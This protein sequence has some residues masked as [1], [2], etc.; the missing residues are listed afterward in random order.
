MTT[1]ITTGLFLQ[2]AYQTLFM[3]GVSFAIGAVLGM[4]L[5]LTLILTRPQGLKQNVPLYTVI[6]T[7]INILRSLPSLILMIAVIPLTHLIVGSS[8]GSTAAIV[9]LTLF[10]TPYIAR[11][12]ENSLLEINTGIIEAADA[13]GATTFQIIWHFMLPEASPSIAL[14]Y[15]TSIITL[16]GAT[17]M[18]GAIGGGGIGD[19][20]ISYGYQ[21]FDNVAM[22]ITVITLIIVVQLLQS[23]G[24]ALSRYFKGN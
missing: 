6:S 16:I 7:I 4:G 15:T 2:S 10:I 1:N 11:L 20:A 12:L 22:I 21:R 17:A 13:M 19:L 3:T 8:I 9:P 23:L 14:S 5:A 24:N 18:A